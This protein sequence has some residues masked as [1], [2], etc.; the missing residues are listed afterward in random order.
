M[1]SLWFLGGLLLF[2]LGIIGEYIG[3]IYL[4]VKHRPRFIISEFIDGNEK[5]SNAMKK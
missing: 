3:K 4:E 1:I 2:S 5:R